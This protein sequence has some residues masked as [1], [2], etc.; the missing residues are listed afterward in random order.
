MNPAVP[1]ESGSTS[2]DGDVLVYTGTGL[3]GA[4]D[5]M[6]VSTAALVALVGSAN[7]DPLV[8]QRRTLEITRGNGLRRFWQIIGHTPGAGDDATVLTL[9]NPTRPGAEWN[10]PDDQSG[11][12]ITNLSPNFFVSE[13]EQVDTVS[14]YNDAVDTDESGTLTSTRLRGLNM[15]PDT[16]I[17]GQ[18]LPGGMTYGNAEVLSVNLGMGGDTFYIDRPGPSS[19]RVTATTRLRPL[20]QQPR[21]DVW[22]LTPGPETIP[23][24]PPLP[25]FP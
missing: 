4:I 8:E 12:D 21:T 10:L 18:R 16:V 1:D 6:T 20:C 14:V 7:L 22:P 17:S 2:S 13:A 9:K 24:M 25:T 11:Y 15:G 19:T 23:S 3:G 5:S